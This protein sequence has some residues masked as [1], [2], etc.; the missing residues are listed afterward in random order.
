VGAT[1]FYARKEIKDVLAYMR[2]VHNP[3]DGV[4]LSR[5]INV[6]PRGTNGHNHEGYQQQDAH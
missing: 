5:I 1:R 3:Y 2:L 4:G 6:P